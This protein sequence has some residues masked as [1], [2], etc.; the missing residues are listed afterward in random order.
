MILLKVLEKKCVSGNLFSYI[1]T[2]LHIQ[3]FDLT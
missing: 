3:K 1:M 2:P